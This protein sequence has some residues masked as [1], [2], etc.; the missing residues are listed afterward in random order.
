MGVSVQYLWAVSIL[1]PEHN[2]FGDSWKSFLSTKLIYWEAK[3]PVTNQIYTI[4]T[5]WTQNFM[6]GLNE[7][8]NRWFLQPTTCMKYFCWLSQC[9]QPDSAHVARFK[10]SG[11][12]ACPIA[13]FLSPPQVASS[14]TMLALN[15]T[16]LQ[17]CFEI[18]LKKNAS[19]SWSAAGYN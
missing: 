4:K 10:H 16:V 13:D 7:Q 19:Y 18:K 9:S 12:W 14:L 11:C 8:C 2:L 1:L 6:S 5:T 15:C 3:P 17:F